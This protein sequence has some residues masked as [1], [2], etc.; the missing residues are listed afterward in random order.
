MQDARREG[1]VL[2]ALS[3]YDALGNGPRGLM[4][5]YAAAREDVMEPALRKL[6]EIWSR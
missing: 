4:F 3:G 1:I 5:G 6:A 2:S